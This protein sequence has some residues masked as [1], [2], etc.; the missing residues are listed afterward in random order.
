MDNFF[1][2][3]IDNNTSGALFV[4]VNRTI[5]YCNEKIEKMFGWPTADVMEKR[6]EFLYGDRRAGKENKEIFEALE[7]KGFHVGPARGR[8]KGGSEID[9]KLSTF[10]IKPYEGAVILIDAP[11]TRK[12]SLIDEFD[13]NLFIQ[14]LLDTIPDM[15]YFTDIDSRFIMVNKAHAATKGLLPEQVVGKSDLDFFPKRIAEKYMA[16]NKE[17]LRT[18]KPVIGKIE[19]AP[20]PDGQFTY[21][22]TTKMPHYDSNGEIIGLIGITRNITEQM[23]A[24]EEL[25]MYK[26]TLEEKIKERTKELEEINERLVRMYHL[27]SEF[28]SVV[29]HEIRT[30]ITIIKEGVALVEDGTLGEINKNQKINLGLALENIERLAR[31]VN[32]I[33]DFS[34]L[35]AKK[36]EF[37]IV[38][39][40]LN[41][42]ISRAAGDYEGKIRQK[43]LEL[44]MELDGLL[45]L[46][47]F[48]KDRVI[49]V[50]YNLI[51]NAVKF[52][53][54]GTVTIE[55]KHSGDRAVVS[56]KDTGR[57][58]KNVDIPRIFEQ[59]EQ[60]Y[61]DEGSRKQGTG[62]GLPI[63]KQII[64]QLGGKI[65]VE[66]RYQ[67][68]SN[69]S[70][71]LPINSTL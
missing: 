38:K 53:D 5:K 32:D 7:K 39:A 67:E 31:L 40:D 36:V 45:P 13:K 4:D 57:G 10:I 61:T 3:L 52:T 66:S 58:I 63:C 1:K 59:F 21:V 9:L 6:T 46:V 29:S 42:V 8:T 43:G 30:P 51:S 17:I 55:S 12:A 23:V 33:L 34:K 56:V 54:K 11:G 47:D 65:S 18:G 48:D 37:K 60:V 20:R 27:K 64:D 70:F 44:K 19:K 15:I 50:L 62:L 71:Y 2:N 28:T 14:N 49:Q 16:D 35:E 25:N 68:G 41:A 26:D 69:F 24:Q 22:S